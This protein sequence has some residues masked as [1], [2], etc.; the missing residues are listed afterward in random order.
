ML[1]VFE[2]VGGGQRQDQNDIMLHLRL[3]GGVGVLEGIRDKGE[4]T[5]CAVFQSAAGMRA[6]RRPECRVVFQRATSS[7]TICTS[8]GGRS[9]AQPFSPFKRWPRRG[10]D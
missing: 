5:C 1:S 6:E 3:G 7:C 9:W 10:A 2:W 4:M 8:K